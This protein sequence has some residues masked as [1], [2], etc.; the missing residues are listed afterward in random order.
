MNKTECCLWNFVLGN[1]QMKGYHFRRKCP[2]LQYTADFLCMQLRLIIEIVDHK[3]TEANL[4]KIKKEKYV[5]LE[6]A[7]FEFL[8]FTTHEIKTK[9]KEVRE[10]IEKR[11]TELEKTFEPSIFLPP[12]TFETLIKQKCLPG[13]LR[14]RTYSEPAGWG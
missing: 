12:A 14:S 6:Q 11:I 10:L 8:Q 2:L 1:K 5:I 13:I 7:G 3:Q 4:D 9:T